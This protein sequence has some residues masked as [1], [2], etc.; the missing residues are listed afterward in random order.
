[1][2]TRIEKKTKL[3]LGKISIVKLNEVQKAAIIGGILPPVECTHL[4]P[5]PPDTY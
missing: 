4:C 3:S 5:P 1:M 2:K